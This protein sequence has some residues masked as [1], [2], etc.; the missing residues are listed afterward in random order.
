MT[1]CAFIHF[2]GCFSEMNMGDKFKGWRVGGEGGGV[3]VTL[4]HLG[5]DSMTLD[6]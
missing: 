2:H 4:V 5:I 6:G 3:G 1:D